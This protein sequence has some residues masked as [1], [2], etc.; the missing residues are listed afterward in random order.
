MKKENESVVI[1]KAK[2]FHPKNKIKD[3]DN[4]DSKI[5]EI[6]GNN[7]NGNY[8]RI[9]VKEGGKKNLVYSEFDVPESLDKNKL[10][11]E[12]NNNKIHSSA[13]NINKNDKTSLNKNKGRIEDKKIAM[14][15]KTKSIE[16]GGD[17]NNIQVTHIINTTMD[18]DFHIIDPLEKVTEEITRKYRK[19]I[20]K[21]NRNGKNG[22]VKVTCS[23]SC[24][25]IKIEPKVK[26]EK[27]VKTQ[28]VSHRENPHL[29]KIIVKNTLRKIALK[30]NGL[31]EA[32]KYFEGPT[33]IV[34]EADDPVSPA[35][36]V[37]EFA[38]KNGKFVIKAGLLDGKVIELDKINA[39]ASLPTKEV[40]IAK[41][42]G[43]LNA[44]ASNFV[45]VLTAVTRNFVC[46]LNAIKEQK[47]KAA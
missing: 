33:A 38:K 25:N 13:R 34:V 7:E 36:I 12:E 16:R 46:V 14:K 8:G 6:K 28:I 3:S 11:G 15:L 26:K 41:M 1:V 42:L 2:S 10:R 35:K 19:I 30:E 5:V 17:Y 24:D 37:S 47:E 32:D 43:S 21:S 18:I 31:S 4:Q 44:P 20:N 39:L 23:C 22:K 45:G 40:L 29:K 27:I 9:Y